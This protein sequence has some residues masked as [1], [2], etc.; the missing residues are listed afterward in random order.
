MEDTTP[1]QNEIQHNVVSNASRGFIGSFGA[2]HYADNFIHPT[3]IIEA[4]AIIGNGNYFGAF[5]YITKDAK[6]GNKTKKAIIEF[7]KANGL[8]ADGKIGQK[9]WGLLSK[10]LNPE[11]VTQE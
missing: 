8:T 7:Q 2:I 10:H 11:P 5:C 6:I 3:A 1:M 4:G 9:T